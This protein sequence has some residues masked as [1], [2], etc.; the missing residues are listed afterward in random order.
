MADPQLVEYV[1]SNMKKFGPAALRERLLTDGVDPA[2]IEAAL[3]EAS[4][5][6]APPARPKSKAAL[7]ALSA[8]AALLILAALLSMEKSQPPQPSA[9]Q[10]DGDG[11]V[12]KGRYGYVLTLPP[13]YTAASS[14]KDA[15]RTHEVVHLAPR[16]TDAQHF[17][18][19]GLYGHFAILRL[20]AAPRRVPQGWID[21]KSLQAWVEGQLKRDKTEYEVRPLALQGMEGFLVVIKEPFPAA[22]A[23][24]IGEKVRYTLFGAAEDELFRQVLSSLSEVAPPAEPEQR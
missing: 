7:Y 20:E 2:E 15:A 4:A 10:A 3:L 1:K 19:E 16:G 22:R 14:F 17:L 18:H 24:M 9:A 13:N 8:G 6:G 21:L 12:F 11:S 5:F 23:Y